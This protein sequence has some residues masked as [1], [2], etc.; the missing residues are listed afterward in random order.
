MGI[1]QIA[2]W[3]CKILKICASCKSYWFNFKTAPAF[4]L[5]VYDGS[6]SVPETG[7]ADGGPGEALGWTCMEQ[8]VLV[9]SRCNS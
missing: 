2:P 4:T 3:N 6:G 1:E 9:Q 5:A 8:F 7:G